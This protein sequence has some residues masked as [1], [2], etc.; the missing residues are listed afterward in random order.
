MNIENEKEVVAGETGYGLK[1]TAKAS[2]AW[3]RI[4][5]PF[6]TA[7][8]AFY[9]WAALQECVSV[10]MYIY[11]SKDMSVGLCN[12][13]VAVSQ[14]FNKVTFTLAQILSAYQADSAQYSENENGFYITYNAL[15]DGDYIVFENFVV[16]GPKVQA[17]NGKVLSD[18]S[19]LTHHCRNRLS[20]RRQ[21]LQLH[22]RLL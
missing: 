20:A 12:L 2:G 7:N 6:K 17:Q 21:L 19:A 18:F 3:G 13:P 4:C 9:S 14:G 11:A 16:N 5:I 1:L 15:N 22:R 10:D 8:G